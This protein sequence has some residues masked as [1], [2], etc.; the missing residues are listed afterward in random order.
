MSLIRKHIKVT[1]YRQQSIWGLHLK[2]KQKQTK[3][4][5]Q[6]TEMAFTGWH[7]VFKTEKSRIFMA[8][9][10]KQK[11]LLDLIQILVQWSSLETIKMCIKMRRFQN[12]GSSILKR[13]ICFPNKTQKQP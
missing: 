5:K 9:L 11:L 6:T 2:R 12:V 10:L 13:K 4:I 1:I 3:D 8:P 7:T